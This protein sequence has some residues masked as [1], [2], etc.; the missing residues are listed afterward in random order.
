MRRQERRAGRTGIG[1]ADQKASVAERRERTRVNT[2]TQKHTPTAEIM[3]EQ[4]ELQ[5]RSLPLYP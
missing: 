5:P 3:D 1:S 2:R 4:R